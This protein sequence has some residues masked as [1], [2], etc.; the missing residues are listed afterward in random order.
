MVTTELKLK[1]VDRLKEV[2]STSG[3]S[4]KRFSTR[5]GINQAQWSRLKS[6]DLESVISDSRFISLAREYSIAM[7]QQMDWKTVQ[8]ATFVYISQLLETC[9]EQNI[10]SMLVDYA[11]LGKTHAAKHYSRNHSNAI[12]I[13]CSQ[14]KSRQLFIREIAKNLGVNHTGKYSDVY[15]DL[16]FYMS[17]IGNL[18]IILDEAGDLKYDAFLEI[19]ALWNAA[20][21]NASFFM[22][23]ADGLKSLFNRAMNNHKVG[24][25]EIF[26]RFGSQYRQVSPCIEEEIKKVK[27]GNN[28][29]NVREALD[30]FRR[31]QVGLVAQANAPAGT[32]IQKLVKASRNSLT[33]LYNMIKVM[34][35]KQAN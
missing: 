30:E 25:A 31:E 27:R 15:K 16:V 10:S 8:T 14:V 35:S 28:A 7:G 6:G 11:D 4:G 22:M 34:N 23:G 17:S 21:G 9:Q 20:E 2:E 19:K 5:I 3:L 29:P 26:R 13:D 33:N 32:D 18:I 1:V 24:Y 12:Y